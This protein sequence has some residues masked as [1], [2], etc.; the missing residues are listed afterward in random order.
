MPHRH[1]SAYLSDPHTHRILGV[2]R[3]I[4]ANF[5]SCSGTVS[6]AF[7]AALDEYHPTQDYVSLLLD[8]G[9]R[10]LIYAGTYDWI[11][12]WIGN[13]RW[14]RS[15]EWSDGDAFGKEELRDWTIGGERVGRVRAKGGLTFATV[16]GAGHMVRFF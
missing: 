14:T 16:E 10:A 12:N 13:E 8:R 5:T 9:V 7:N 4:T 1:I 6:N 11:C 15:L 2:D 3:S